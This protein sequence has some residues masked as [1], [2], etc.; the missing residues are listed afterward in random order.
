MLTHPAS[1]LCW[2]ILSVQAL[3]GFTVNFT[4]LDGR[5]LAIPINNGNPPSYKEVVP[6]E[7]MPIQ[8]EPSKRGNLRSKFN[9]KLPT[10]LA[11]EHEAG[12]KKLSGY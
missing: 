9:I 5:S 11:A 10:W 3:T 7:G 8:K 4:N 1:S 6:G 2:L 12:I